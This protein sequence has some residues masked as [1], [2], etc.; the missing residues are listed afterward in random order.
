VVR[1]NLLYK[2][3]SSRANRLFFA[4]G[5]RDPWREVT[6]STDFLPLVSTEQQ[7]IAV[8]SGGYHCSDLIISYGNV[9][10]SIKQVQNLGAAYMAKWV[11]AWHAAHPEAPKGKNATIVD[12]QTLPRPE[13]RKMDIPTTIVD[14]PP[15][16][17]PE[18]ALTPG[19]PTVNRKAN[20]VVGNAMVQPTL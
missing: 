16:E 9:D 8:A 1:T 15:L 5:Q 12:P 17:Q 7:P 10:A 14:A 13:G 6:M 2:G 3:F 11:A 20:K 4:N 18:L 19:S